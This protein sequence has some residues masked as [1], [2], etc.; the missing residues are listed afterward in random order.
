M[1]PILFSI[2]SLPDFL[3]RTHVLKAFLSIKLCVLNNNYYFY[4]ITSVAILSWPNSS[5][6]LVFRGSCV[7]F[8]QVFVF[9]KKKFIYLFYFWLDWVFVAAL[10]FLQLQ[11]GGY[12]L[13][14]CSGF[15]LL[16][17]TGSKGQ[18]KRHSGLVAPK[19]V[20]FSWTRD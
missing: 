4:A 13:L 17:S 19:Q 5:K 16:W 6:Y 14:Q 18:V 12:S 1:D 10:A 8:L 3:P 7:A 20:E 9:K 2:R 15:L 11:G